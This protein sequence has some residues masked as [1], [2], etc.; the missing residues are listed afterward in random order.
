[1]LPFE[2]ILDIL[3]LFFIIQAFGLVSFFV[4]YISS[5]FLV[6]IHEKAS[7]V[8]HCASRISLV[9]CAAAMIPFF[10]VAVLFAFAL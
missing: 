3:K 8:M 2:I 9:V 1:M 5:R 7:D 6:N 10:A 4:C